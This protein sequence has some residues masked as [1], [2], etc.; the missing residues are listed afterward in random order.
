MTWA[1]TALSIGMCIMLCFVFSNKVI[2]QDKGVS[3]ELMKKYKTLVKKSFD[4][5]GNPG[6]IYKKDVDRMNKT[7]AQMSEEQKKSLPKLKVPPP[8]IPSKS[9]VIP[10]KPSVPPA[11]LV[12]VKVPKA[13]K[14][15]KR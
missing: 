9:G 8:P 5:D 11:P 10:P 12:P 13:E 6:M 15:L 2:A 7:Y 1:K 14:V 3:N 4:K